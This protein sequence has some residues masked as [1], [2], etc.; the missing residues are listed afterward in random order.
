MNPLH[1]PANNYID[2][3]PDEV[4]SKLFGMLPSS[5][6]FVATVSRRF[7]DL[8]GAAVENKRQNKTYKYSIES[9]GAL[10]ML[11][12]EQQRLSGYWGLSRDANISLIGAGCGRIEWVERGGVFNGG[13]CH[14]AARG[15]QFRILK[16]LRVKLGKSWND[17]GWDM[18]CGAAGG[19][20]LEILKWLKEEGCEWDSDRSREIMFS[21]VCTAAAKSGHLG[22]LRW[23]IENGCTWDQETCSEARRGGHFNILR[24]LI[25][26][27]CDYHEGY[28]N[29]IT[30][31]EFL[32]WF[33][34]Y[35]TERDGRD[36][37]HDDDM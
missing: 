19:G 2:A 31:N 22:I 36:D 20:H 10:E 32:N 33:E 6:R 28:F 16:W 30:D 25:E 27:G 26:N 18:C 17:L 37:D 35:K 34:A 1:A 23:A 15:G 7:R 12:E 8:H 14:A 5:Y 4:L 3:V 29:R 11:L 21:G 13:T 24:W 9:E